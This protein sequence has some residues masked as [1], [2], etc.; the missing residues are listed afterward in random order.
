MECLFR[1]SGISASAAELSHLPRLAPRG[2]CIC[3][4]N[5]RFRFWDTFP[6]FSVIVRVRTIQRVSGSKR[7]NTDCLIGFNYIS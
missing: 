6:S 1:S 4:L 7:R 5:C 3:E 2:Q